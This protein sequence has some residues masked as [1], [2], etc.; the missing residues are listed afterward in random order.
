MVLYHTHIYAKSKC[1]TPAG[2]IANH[3]N[4]HII[5]DNMWG[6]GC[7]NCIY[8][9]LQKDL[10][11]TAKIDILKIQNR[12][13]VQE[14]FDGVQ[15]TVLADMFLHTPH[16]IDKVQQLTF[17]TSITADTL[18]DLV[19]REAEHAWNMWAAQQLI[20]RFGSFHSASE[21]GPQR[22]QPTQ[23]SHLLQ[24]A[25][26]DPGLCFYHNSLMKVP[27]AMVIENKAAFEAWQPYP[28]PSKL[29]GKPP[30]YCPVPSPEK[31]D[32]MQAW[33]D[34]E[35]KARCHAT[36]LAVPCIRHRLIDAFI[37]CPGELMDNLAEDYAAMKGG[38]HPGPY[39]NHTRTYTVAHTLIH[40]LMYTLTHTLTHTL[41]HTSTHTLTQIPTQP[42]HMPTPYH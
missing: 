1:N 34:K 27:D 5:R 26:L 6:G 16:I 7:F 18:V 42:T 17:T 35:M 40:T 31:D 19:G 28:A 41:A 15:F 14:D 13:G 39:L 30:P 33:I 11:K 9:T 37:P 4:I 23:F 38:A 36:R 10:L 29:W 22:L 8:K 25:K 24:Q 12:A 2:K 20:S 3:P 21:M 32:E